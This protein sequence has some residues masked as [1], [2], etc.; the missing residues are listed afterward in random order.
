MPRLGATMVVEIAKAFN[1]TARKSN[2]DYQYDYLC[3]L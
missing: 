1:G 2:Y 3:D